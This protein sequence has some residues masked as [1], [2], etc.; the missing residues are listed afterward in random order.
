MSKK[1]SSI[2][3]LNEVKGGTCFLNPAH[4]STIQISF[5]NI[6]DDEKKIFEEYLNFIVEKEILNKINEK[7]YT[8]V[9]SVALERYRDDINLKI[10]K[11]NDFITFVKY[12]IEK[13]S[14]EPQFNISDIEYTNIKTSIEKVD[15][16]Y[17]DYRTYKKYDSIKRKELSEALNRIF[18]NFENLKISDYNGYKILQ[19]TKKIIKD[20]FVKNFFDQW[21]IDSITFEKYFFF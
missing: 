19:E 17:Q 5:Y 21:E 2:I 3:G 11:L 10:N 18:L 16:I 7:T 1:P 9:E 15:L 13:K 12:Y 20:D 8:F 6:H 4:L 14:Y